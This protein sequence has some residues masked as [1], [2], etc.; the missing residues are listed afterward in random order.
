MS[1]QDDSQPSQDSVLTAIVE[2]RREV[3][4]FAYG[5][6]LSTEQMRH[7]CPYSLPIGLGHLEGW[8]WIIN[9]RGYANIVRLSDLPARDTG[10]ERPEPVVSAEGG[11][12]GLLYL[13]PPSDEEKLDGYEGVPWAYGKEH[14][15]VRRVRDDKGRRLEGEEP[16]MV[17]A[18]VYVDSQRVEGAVPVEEYVGRMEKGIA[19]AVGDWGLDG[20]Y[21]EGLRRWLGESKV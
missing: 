13:V 4:Y 8:G 1:S 20:G 3:I 6:N 18:L 9:A 2:D 21:A 5:S 19:E 15:S 14:L 17:T 10:R 12:Y 7:R 11:V 16:E